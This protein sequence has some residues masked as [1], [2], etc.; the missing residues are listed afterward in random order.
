M[1]DYAERHFSPQEVVV[2]ISLVNDVN[3][4]SPVLNYVPPGG[5]IYYDLD[6]AGQ[7]VLNP[8]SAGSRAEFDRTLEFSHQ[9]FLVTLPVTLESYCMIL[10]LSDSLRDKFR[11][12]HAI[13][14]MAAAD[15]EAAKY[16]R[17]GL[18]LKPYDLAPG[19]EAQ[20]AMAVMLAELTLLKQ[21]CDAHGVK[22]RL[23]TI[24]FFPPPFYA[25]QHGVAWTLRL[26]NKYDFLAPDKQIAAFADSQG[27]P[28]L[29]FADW[30]L[31]KKIS[32]EEIHTFYFTEGSG[33]FTERGHAKCAEAIFE[34]FYAKP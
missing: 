17:I 12:R 25:T 10:Q 16:G 5:F 33:H 30:L 3:E 20:H 9:S 32:A 34:T 31:A 14:G 21:K 27:I 7:L 29:S 2:T 24:P 28:F 15:P 1:F 18:S 23:V 13:S 11:R 4:S 19:P 8:A 26:D 6:S 22:L